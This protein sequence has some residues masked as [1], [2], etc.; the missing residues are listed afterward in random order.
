MKRTLVR[1]SS[2]KILNIPF[3]RSFDCLCFRLRIWRRTQAWYR[4]FHVCGR[5]D[6]AYYVLFLEQTV[7]TLW[8]RPMP[9]SFY[10]P[11]HAAVV[12]VAVPRIVTISDGA[13]DDVLARIV[14]RLVRTHHQEPTGAEKL[15]KQEKSKEL[16]LILVRCAL[17]E[18]RKHFSKQRLSRIVDLKRRIPWESPHSISSTMYSTK[19]L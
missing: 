10:V 8:S 4:R 7:Y 12:V 2:L 3:N 13:E 1:N 16:V 17:I 6:S 5:R 14:D 15:L 18:R 11:W 19:V 9:L